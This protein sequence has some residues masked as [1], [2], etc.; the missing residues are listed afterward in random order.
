L[1]IFISGLSIGASM[2]ILIMCM[3]RVLAEDDEE[4]LGKN[5]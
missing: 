2:G 3:L 5:A 4:D 1:S